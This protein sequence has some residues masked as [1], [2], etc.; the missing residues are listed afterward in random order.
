MPPHGSTP[1]SAPP[2]PDPSR[3]SIALIPEVDTVYTEPFHI[4][5]QLASLDYVS[6]GRAG[7]LVAASTS[8]ADAAAVGRETVAETGWRRKP[9][10]PSRS[11]AG[12]GTAGRTTP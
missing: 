9:R 12:S 5:T 3:S 11:A 1:C 4:S 10:T 6:G 8:S 2:S 7:W